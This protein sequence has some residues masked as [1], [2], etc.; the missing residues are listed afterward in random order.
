VTSLEHLGTVPGVQACKFFSQ[1]SLV[2]TIYLTTEYVIVTDWDRGVQAKWTPEPVQI[3]RR[4]RVA[5]EVLKARAIDRYS[6]F[7]NTY[8]SKEFA[9]VLGP[10]QIV[11]S[12]EH[13]GTVPGVQ[14]TCRWQKRLHT[15]LSYNVN[16]AISGYQT[17][18]IKWY[19]I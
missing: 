10:G 1:I 6:N 13:L 14:V 16:I 5:V 9:R 2:V 15:S 17:H 19:F 8:L 12:L 18:N 4:D 11:T 7:G 3:V